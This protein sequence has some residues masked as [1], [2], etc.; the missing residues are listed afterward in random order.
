[1][2][3]FSGLHLSIGSPLVDTGNPETCTSDD[4]SGCDPDG[5]RPDMGIC[6][7][8]GA[9]GWDRD[10]DGWHDWFWPGSIG[11]P[12]AGFDPSQWDADDRDAEFH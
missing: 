12:P 6:G 7:G 4:V 2:W 3:V 8:A 1:M 11:T 5:A 10:S 9:D